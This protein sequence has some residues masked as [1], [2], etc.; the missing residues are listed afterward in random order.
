MAHVHSMLYVL[1]W[2]EEGNL[3]AAAYFSLQE[4][5]MF[6]KVLI[7][8]VSQRGSKGRKQGE[9]INKRKSKVLILNYALGI[10][11]RREPS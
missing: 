7:E 9:A 11:I 10:N 5:T 3:V 2:G 8:K 4:K 6:E 1:G